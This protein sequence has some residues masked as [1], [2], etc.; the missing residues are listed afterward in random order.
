MPRYNLAGGQGDP[1]MGQLHNFVIG[2][3]VIL[4]ILIIANGYGQGHEQSA[5]QLYWAA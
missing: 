2:L 3:V 4:A 5:R 1:S